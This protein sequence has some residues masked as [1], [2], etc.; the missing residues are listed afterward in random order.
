MEGALEEPQPDS[1][2][3]ETTLSVAKRGVGSPCSKGARSILSESGR[4]VERCTPTVLP[5]AEEM[6]LCLP[7]SDR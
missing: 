5:T 6:H 7:P 4:T 3:L 1:G 2:A